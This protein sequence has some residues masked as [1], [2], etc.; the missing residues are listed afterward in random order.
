MC[1]I[2]GFIHKESVEKSVLIKMN[3]TINYR[4]PDDSGY[5]IENVKN[6]IQV[7]FAHKRLAILDLSPL[8]H[9]PMISDDNNI[10]VV[11]NGEIYNFKEIKKDLIAKG[12]KFKSNSDTEAILYSYKEYGIK[13]VEK[14]NGMF[15]IAIYDKLND[16]VYLIRDRLGVKPLYYYIN[17]D[18]I[19]FASELKPI[20]KYP[21]FKKEINDHALGL[22]LNHGYI[23]AP[24]T[25]FNNTYKIKPGFYLKIKDGKI[26]ENCYWSLDN[27]IKRGRL[28]YKEEEYLK[29]L[30][31][32]LNSSINY[33]MISDVP[34]GAFLSGGIDSSLVTAIMQKNSQKP[35]KTFT[36]GFEEKRFNEAKYAKE[37]AK[38]L[39]TEHYEEY[40]P[41]KKAEELIFEMPKY[42]DE[43]F[44]DASQLATYL[45][46]KIAKKHVTV[47]LS[48]D[49]GD[50]LFC[51][52]SRY[53]KSTELQKY[54]AIAYII[55]NLTSNDIKSNIYNRKL[56]KL[57]QL[58]SDINI[59]NSD[60]LT[61]N[62][63]ITRLLK[64]QHIIDKKYFESNKYKNKNIKEKYMISDMITYLPDDILTK[65]DRASMAVSLESRNPI[66]DYR[67]VEYAF[68][69]PEK[70]LFK[71][72][73][74]YVLKQL[75][76]KYIPKEL[77]DRPK[78]GFGV[79]INEWLHKDYRKYIDKYLNE[80]YILKQNI[81]NYS[82]IK[83]IISKFDKN[84][85]VFIDNLV[86]RILMFQLW[87]EEYINY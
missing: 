75:L 7:G 72:D 44:A 65:V 54:K 84:K 83:L 4:G 30:D 48:G 28:Y 73:L 14:F 17:N 81:F 41:M 71:D 49:G 70:L 62:Q 36:I 22:Y 63:I 69:C 55:K 78:Q 33:R 45:V 64:S 43:P 51:G 10:V 15:A 24:Y 34:I 3:N 76:Y 59:I 66:I 20:M 29:E 61:T 39:G 67:V 27:V 18:K 25:I 58:T 74:K 8:G 50:E 5:F 9:Q 13:C 11:F 38:Y 57:S 47:V 52:Y 37:I 21:F 85:D 53:Y 60:Y 2:C 16:E 23:T 80:Q 1:G 35:V 26:N 79:P 86:W 32:L 77:V 31:S 6:G 12:Y 87:Y 82:Y 56:N 68:N 19:A 40:L 42:Y 46:C